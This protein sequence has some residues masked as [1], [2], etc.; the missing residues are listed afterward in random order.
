VIDGVIVATEHA[1]AVHAL[2]ESFRDDAI[3]EASRARS[4]EALRLWKRFVVGLRITERVNTYGGITRD[5]A[6]VD[7]SD[8]GV[9]DDKGINRDVT[10]IGLPSNGFEDAPLTTAGRFSISEL[11]Q[12][13]KRANR[14]PKTKKKKK[15]LDDDLDDEDSDQYDEQYGSS[16]DNDLAGPIH[17]ND[18]D[19]GAGGGFLPEDA[20]VDDSMMGG[21]FLPEDSVDDDRIPG[22]GFLPDTE[23]ADDDVA[24][25][26]FL[27]T[28]ED[29][30]NDM[31]GGGF[32]LED[33]DESKHN[34][35][36]NEARISVAEQHSD[37]SAD[38]A[39]LEPQDMALHTISSG[40]PNAITVELSQ[41]GPVG[42]EHT[43]RLFAEPSHAV[44]VPK[45]LSSPTTTKADLDQGYSQSSLPLDRRQSEDEDS[46]MSHDPEDEDAEPD[47]L[48]SD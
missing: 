31:A 8:T 24:S 40:P 35:A 9:N 13:R 4:L 48:E 18:F 1:D 2:L 26:G 10:G 39:E 47:W 33:T 34:S 6:S 36:E 19:D 41:T 27:P 12:P 21:G 7:T 16:S 43:N 28:I 20:D 15:K 14:A 17:D 30:D 5:Q 44:S 37:L 38:D 46:I 29:G 45:Y 11:S 22:G 42:T 25:G 3:E 23:D 32:L